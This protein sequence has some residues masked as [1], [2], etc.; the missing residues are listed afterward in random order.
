LRYLTQLDGWNVAWRSYTE[1][2]FDSCGPFK[3]VVV[4]IMSTLD[5]LER[6][7]ISERTKAG[8]AGAIRKGKRLGRPQSLNPSRTTLWR[9]SKSKDYLGQL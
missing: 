1:P 8:L 2:F 7:K 6:V 4:S 9:R 3:D 5:N